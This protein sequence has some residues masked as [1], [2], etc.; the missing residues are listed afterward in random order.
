MCNFQALWGTLQFFY[1]LLTIVARIMRQWKEVR[2]LLK[3]LCVMMNIRIIALHV[4][5]NHQFLWKMALLGKQG[6]Q[7]NWWISLSPFFAVEIPIFQGYFCLPFPPLFFKKNPYDYDYYSL[8]QKKWKRQT[9]PIQA[10]NHTI[11]QLLLSAAAY[12][13]TTIPPQQQWEV[14]YKRS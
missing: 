13:C 6:L 1:C 2:N 9:M 11:F 4:R 7:W 3:V 8:W 12:F 5:K 10:I 14:G